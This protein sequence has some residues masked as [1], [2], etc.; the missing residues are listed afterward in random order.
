VHRGSTHRRPGEDIVSRP[1]LGP[2]AIIVSGPPASGKT[3]LGEALARAVG[4]AI[5][6]LDTLTGP[7]TRAALR[8]READESAI[9]T[10]AGARLRAARYQTLIDT[11]AANLQVGVG[12]VLCAPFTRERSSPGRFQELVGRLQQGDPDLG[13][14]LLYIDAPPEV[15]RARLRDRNAPR[16]RAKLARPLE[17]AGPASLVPGAIVLDGTQAVTEQLAYVLNA[18]RR[19]EGR[20]AGAAEAQPC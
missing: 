6:D 5:M 12:V 9:D 8:H 20:R 11:A 3:T 17:L 16:D 19:L 7:L 1:A 18:L 4:Y 2:A 14:I 15:V 10:A 13:V